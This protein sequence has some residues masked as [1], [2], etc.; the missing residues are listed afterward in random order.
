[1]VNLKKKKKHMVNLTFLSVQVVLT[2]EKKDQLHK[3]DIS[4]LQSKCNFK[5][6]LVQS[7]FSNFCSS[8]YS[9]DNNAVQFSM[10]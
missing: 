4:F 1:M 2:W 8:I 5:W 10:Y 3:L 7:L 6:Y 9:F